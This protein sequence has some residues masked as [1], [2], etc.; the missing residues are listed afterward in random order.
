[1]APAFVAGLL[2]GA[3]VTLLAL[4][5]HRRRL[6]AKVIRMKLQLNT[7][8]G[9]IGS[10]HPTLPKPALSKKVRWPSP[11]QETQPVVED[12]PCITGAR[13]LHNELDEL[14]RDGYA[15]GQAAGEGM[16]LDELE[17]RIENNHRT[18]FLTE[19]FATAARCAG[20]VL[21]FTHRKLQLANEQAANN[22]QIHEE[23]HHEDLRPH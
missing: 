20:R 7:M 18:G 5:L 3:V 2:V 9:K 8:Y 10:I 15:E 19:D 6:Q 17:V 13:K 22:Q 1:M 11:S 4:E 23:I 12:W 14:V 16:G 21:A